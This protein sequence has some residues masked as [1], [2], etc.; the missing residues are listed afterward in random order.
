MNKI[1]ITNSSIRNPIFYLVLLL[2]GFIGYG[3]ASYTNYAYS[4]NN[5][6]DAAEHYIDEFISKLTTLH[7]EF[8][9]IEKALQSEKTPN[10]LLQDLKRSIDELNKSLF[11]S[12]LTIKKLQLIQNDLDSLA[13]QLSE[14]SSFV[15]HTNAATIAHLKPEMRRLENQV[16]HLKK[17]TLIAMHDDDICCVPS[18][19][20][21]SYEVVFSAF[22][23]GSFFILMLL[24]LIIAVIVGAGAYIR[25]KLW[26]EFTREIKSGRERMVSDLGKST[27]KLQSSYANL[28]STVREQQEIIE[29]YMEDYAKLS[30]A[31][32]DARIAYYSFCEYKAGLKRIKQYAEN[33]LGR[34]KYELLEDI[35]QNDIPTELWV[36]Y[37]QTI[38]ELEKAARLTE[39]TLENLRGLLLV[40]QEKITKLTS[41]L[42]PHYVFNLMYYYTELFRHYTAS[43]NGEFGRENWSADKYRS[44][45]LALLGESKEYDHLSTQR[46]HY[47]ESQLHTEYYTQYDE[48]KLNE[49]KRNRLN[50]SIMELYEYSSSLQEPDWLELMRKKWNTL[51][52]R[53]I[54]G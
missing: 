10:I 47:R 17:T 16:L 19:H 14:L 24:A 25:Q 49:I 1:K 41:E 12:P 27:Q 22:Y 30:A 2:V 29:K 31:V 26:D 6:T 50:L 7:S 28:S 37:Y 46:H 21:Q 38:A 9:L 39:S 43:D 36:D 48:L 33:N 52:A 11:Q 54:K 23:N 13:A 8:L 32:T 34:D 3:S 51:L 5:K 15:E 4:D 40:K 53:L 18:N 35:V 20:K 45:A 44:E 42:I